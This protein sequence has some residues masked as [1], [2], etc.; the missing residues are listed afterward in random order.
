MDCSF[1]FNLLNLLV[2]RG[3]VFLQEKTGVMPNLVLQLGMFEGVGLGR[4]SYTLEI[5]V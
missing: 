1:K 2:L 3:E 5:G 4:L